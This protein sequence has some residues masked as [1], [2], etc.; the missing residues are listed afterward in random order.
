MFRDVFLMT[1]AATGQGKIISPSNLFR[2]KDQWK[3]KYETANNKQNQ[4]H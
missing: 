2:E 3:S 1:S 4:I